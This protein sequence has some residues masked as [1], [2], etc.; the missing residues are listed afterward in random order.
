MFGD[1]IGGGQQFAHGDAQG[2]CRQA[3]KDRALSAVQL[4]RT[5]RLGPPRCRF[6]RT[7][8]REKH[9]EGKIYKMPHGIAVEV[10]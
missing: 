2:R 3:G 9:R 5:K 7:P 4:E 8:R 6:K 1:E 10:G